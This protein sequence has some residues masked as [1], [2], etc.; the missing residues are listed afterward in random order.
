M[1]RGRRPPADRHLCGR[2]PPGCLPLFRRAHPGPVR[3][4]PPR[5]GRSGP[6][7]SPSSPGQLPAVLPVVPPA[8]ADPWEGGRPPDRLKGEEELRI[9]RIVEEAYRGY[10]KEYT[11]RGRRLTV[12]VPFALNDER[13][14]GRGYTQTFFRHGKGTPDELWPYI[15]G[16]LASRRFARYAD[17]L[18]GSGS[19]VFVF[20]LVRRTYTVS[21]EAR[22]LEAMQSGAYPGTPTR[23]YVLKN[24]REVTSSD[25]YNYLYAIASVGVDCS[26]FSH[27]VQRSVAA[28]YGVDLDALLAESM[29][30]KPQEVRYRLGVRLY[31]PA[32]R[33]TETVGDRIEDL[34]PADLI[35]Y[36]GSDGTFKHSAVILSIDLEEGLIR[37]VQ[38]TDWSS[39]E[40]RGVHLSEIRFDPDQVRVGLRHH[41]VRWLQQV[42]PPFE[43]ELEPR[44]WLNDGDRYLWYTEGGGSLVARPRYLAPALLKADPLFYTNIYADE[45]LPVEQPPGGRTGA[46]RF[47]D[48][49][50]PLTRSICSWTRRISSLAW[51]ALLM[52]LSSFP[53]PRSASAWAICCPAWARTARMAATSSPVPRGSAASRPSAACS[54]V[55]ASEI[56]A[57]A[58][59]ASCSFFLAASV[60]AC[61]A[62]R[63][64]S[65]ARI[66]ACR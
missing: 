64:A 14:G 4:P 5:P 62:R 30:V 48:G 37:Y 19:K 31:D 2:R 66:R 29:G 27:Q 39:M 57:P 46:Y 65:S 9:E 51:E 47:F 12:R 13:E 26:G 44:D 43:G 25:I 56:S 35:L 11:I 21:R 20:N 28:A 58:S 53:A 52:A 16:V 18:A 42:R 61:L 50:W 3:S 49:A 10:Q 17:H 7:R 45:Q 24:D 8:S 23:I 60:P 41:T 40:D 1:P 38:S 34:R 59:L 32:N 55:F 22:L 63:A 15:D 54:R 36:R 33:Y 6:R